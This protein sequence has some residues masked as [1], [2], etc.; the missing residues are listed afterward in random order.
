MK[1]N[2]RHGRFAARA[3]RHL[4]PV[5][6]GRILSVQKKYVFEKIRLDV[7][8]FCGKEKRKCY[9]V[10]KSLRIL[11]IIYLLTK[12]IHFKQIIIILIGL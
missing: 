8:G 4:L 1:K 11:Y 3:R 2:G 7:C 10:N 5:A 6:S 12:L 9:Y